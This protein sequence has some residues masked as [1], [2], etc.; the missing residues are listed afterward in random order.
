MKYLTDKQVAN[1]KPR[2]S[3]YF[4]ADPECRGHFIRVGKSS[5]SFVCTARNPHTGQIWH[6]IG[7]TTHHKIEDARDEARAAIKRIKAGLSP[8]EPLPPKPLSFENVARDWLE[9]EAVKFRTLKDVTRCLEKYVFP[10]WS[11]LHFESIKRTDIKALLDGI[12]KK[13]GKRQADLVLANI[14]SIAHWY[15]TWHDD[16]ISPVIKG[17][18]KGKRVARERFLDDSEVRKV[19]KLAGD[20]GTFGAFVRMLLLTAQRR[21]SVLAMRWDDIDGS[22]WTIPKEDRAKGNLGAVKLPA[23]A[24]AII[25]TQPR[26]A[27]NEFVFASDRTDG[28][29]AGLGKSK[30]RFAERCKLASRWTL[31]DLRRTARSLLSRCDVRIDISER[32]MGH[33]RPTIEAT[34][35]KHSYIDEK[36]DALAKLANLIAEIV[37][38]APDKVFRL[39]TKARANA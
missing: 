13:H 23:P 33:A 11:E 9:Q 8:V 2:A 15:A 28:P 32:V 34:Y 14:A 4:Y 7:N 25:E 3:R 37:G 36:S 10:H 17:M 19:W 16:Y 5:K 18:R 6:T 21:G 38:D 30:N 12:A 26:I 20:E 29:L 1:L 39:K 27:N 24:L 31:H 22:T 35:D